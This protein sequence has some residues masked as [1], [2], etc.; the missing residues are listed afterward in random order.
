MLPV[1]CRV[2]GWIQRI[3]LAST[4]CMLAHLQHRQVTKLPGGILRAVVHKLQ[5]W[6][7]CRA[8]TCGTALGSGQPYTHARGFAYGVC[9]RLMERRLHA[10]TKGVAGQ[11]QQA[12]CQTA[13]EKKTMSSTANRLAWRRTMKQ[14]TAK[15]LTR[16]QLGPTSN[17]AAGQTGLS[18]AVWCDLWL[19]RRGWTG[20]VVRTERHGCRTEPLCRDR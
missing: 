6:C 19:P 7:D 5:L 16:R 8:S 9:I 13:L 15:L 4:P 14:R 3:Y 1:V 2:A 12:C 17:N 11:A 10:R 18:R 20:S